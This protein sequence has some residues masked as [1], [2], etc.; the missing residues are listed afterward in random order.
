VQTECQTLQLHLELDYYVG[1]ETLRFHV[2]FVPREPA[3]QLILQIGSVNQ[4][5]KM[6]IFLYIVIRIY[7]DC[8][9]DSLKN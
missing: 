2:R 1:R 6:F 9:A 4:I 8:D 7:L 3:F 5:N